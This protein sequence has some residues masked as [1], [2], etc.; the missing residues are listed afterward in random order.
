MDSNPLPVLERR[1]PYVE[2][3]HADAQ[4]KRSRENTP[5]EAQSPV[6]E[7]QCKKLA[8]FHKFGAVNY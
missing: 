2:N 6:V 8:G 3:S 4:K 1:L 5:A 7:L